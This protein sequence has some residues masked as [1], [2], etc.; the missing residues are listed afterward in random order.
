LGR[1]STGWIAPACLAHSF[2]HLVGALEQLLQQAQAERFQVSPT[3]RR[4]SIARAALCSFRSGAV[5][6]QPLF[7]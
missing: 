4:S 7:R 3:R 5:A 1:T 6:R 2:D